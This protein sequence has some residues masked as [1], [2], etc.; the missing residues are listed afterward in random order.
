MHAL[1]FSIL[2]GAWAVARI[3]PDR[4]LPAPEL[5][6]SL[7]LS[8][9]RTADEISVVCPEQAAP[10]GARV[11]AG[12][13]VMKL[14]G[15]FPFDLTGILVSFAAPL[16]EAGIGIFAISTFDTDYLLVKTARLDDALEALAAA[17]HELVEE[18][19]G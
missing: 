1:R 10:E 16:A 19:G 11:E 8:I 3:E 14:H 4:P 2:P 7:F 5:S 15:P 12:W 9:T 18:S 6:A 17:G 13:S